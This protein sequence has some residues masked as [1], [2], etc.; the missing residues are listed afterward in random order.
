MGSGEAR[1][2]RDGT[3]FLN[4]LDVQEAVESV[5]TEINTALKGYDT[6]DQKTIDTIHLLKFLHYILKQ[7]FFG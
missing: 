2:R 6:R 3:E 5:N 4:G 7:L 1:E